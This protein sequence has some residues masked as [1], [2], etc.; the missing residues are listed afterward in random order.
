[1]QTLDQRLGQY[2]S[3]A[4]RSL[5]FIE[6]KSAAEYVN[7][8]LVDISKKFCNQL[9]NLDSKKDNLG[10]NTD[11][12]FDLAHVWDKVEREE[13]IAPSAG[14]NYQ[15]FLLFLLAEHGKAFYSKV[16]FRLRLY[17]YAFATGLIIAVTVLLALALL[18]GILPPANVFFPTKEYSLYFV[19]IWAGI[20]ILL[21]LGTIVYSLWGDDY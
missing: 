21:A 10:L 6:R 15:D 9:K 16:H 3:L 12:F 5:I 1:L 8:S 7:T 17:S 13:E 2:R 11:A 19:T 14:Q 20:G 4:I 18:S